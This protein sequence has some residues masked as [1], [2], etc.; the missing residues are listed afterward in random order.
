MNMNI[1]TYICIYAY[2][3]LCLDISDWSGCLQGKEWVWGDGPQIIDE[4]VGLAIHH[5]QQTKA[6]DCM[7]TGC[8]P[9]QN[10][11]KAGANLCACVCS[12]ISSLWILLATVSS[13]PASFIYTKAKTL[14]RAKGKK[15]Q[16]SSGREHT[17]HWFLAYPASSLWI[18]VDPNWT[19]SGQHPWLR[20]SDIRCLLFLLLSQF[21][22]IRGGIGSP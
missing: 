4:S 1:G 11:W 20:L 21:N 15:Q 5:K 18:P 10:L 17:F 12:C 14:T 13:N 19:M 22:C 6:Y 16:T 9:L 3:I 8:A 2:N 7:V